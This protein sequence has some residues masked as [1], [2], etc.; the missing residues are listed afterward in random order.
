MEKT[1]A[2]EQLDS[3]DNFVSGT[4]LKPINVNN[5]KEAFVVIGVAIFEAEDGTQ[6][7]RLT[8]ERNEKEFEFDLNKTNAV[9]LKNSGIG[10]PKELIGK[11]IYFKKV[12]VRNPKTNQ[13]VES[14]RIL[15]VD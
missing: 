8:L 2:Q 5:D 4:F 12:L 13:E 1:K 6:R 9:F 7:P 11:K 15:K 3:W 10:S 14:L